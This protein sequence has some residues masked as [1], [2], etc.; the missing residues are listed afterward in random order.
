MNK[1]SL[2]VV[3]LL[4]LI[5]LSLFVFAKLDVI[6]SKKT[7]DK[8]YKVVDG[9]VEEWTLTKIIDVSKLEKIK[10]DFEKM[11]IDLENT[12][13]Y[14]DSCVK[15]CEWICN[16]EFN[17]EAE[18]LLSFEKVKL[19]KSYYFDCVKNCEWVC[20]DEAENEIVLLNNRIV[21]L[22]EDI[23]EVNKIK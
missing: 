14:Y 1:K 22:E 5:L 4:L 9:L 13:D 8:D 20:N 11:K 19:D 15:N 7:G 12:D 10:D 21:D 2:I 16:D 3:G 17:R 23:K 18:I 6:F